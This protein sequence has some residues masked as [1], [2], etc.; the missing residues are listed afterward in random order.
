MNLA[1]TRV[2]PT[3]AIPVWAVLESE[4]RTG[5]RSREACCD[6]R[7]ISCAYKE[8]AFGL[9]A[10]APES[11]G[12]LGRREIRRPDTFFVGFIFIWVG[13]SDH[14]EGNVV[15]VR[16]HARIVPGIE[17]VQ[18]CLRTLVRVAHQDLQGSAAH[19]RPFICGAR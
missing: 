2:A 16:V 8:H 4:G 10:A 15:R 7:S 14:D 17:L 1:H 11:G 18:C 3:D 6:A 13:V 5:V 19:R 9:V 12:H